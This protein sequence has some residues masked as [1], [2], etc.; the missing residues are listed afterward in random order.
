VPL[1]L[2]LQSNL[3]AELETRAVVPMC[4][5]STFKEKALRRLMPV[6]EIEGKTFVCLV[7]QLA[8]IP[9]QLVG[10]AVADLSAHRG[11]IVAALDFL[12]TGF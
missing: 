8:S 6:V 10:P 3:L 4:L 9:R 1:L 7:P 5:A 11:E 2:D 12:L